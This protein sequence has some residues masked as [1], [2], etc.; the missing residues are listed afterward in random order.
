MDKF[1]RYEIRLVIECVDGIGNRFCESLESPQTLEQAKA[2]PTYIQ[3]YWTL[4][5]HLTGEGVRA[6][7]DSSDYAGAV[8]MYSLITGDYALTGVDIYNTNEKEG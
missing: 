2:E 3:H 7:F 5:G 6:I 8:E 4:Y 1:D